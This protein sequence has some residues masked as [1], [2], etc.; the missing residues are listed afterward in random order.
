MDEGRVSSTGGIL[1]IGFR[2]GEGEYSHMEA[3]HGV[4]RG[5]ARGEKGV[6]AWS[7]NG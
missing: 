3:K 2:V 7:G 5:R 6:T 4:G 1:G